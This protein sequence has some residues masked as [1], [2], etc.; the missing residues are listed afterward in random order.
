MSGYTTRGRYPGRD[1]G[2]TVPREARTGQAPPRSRHVIR[3]ADWDGSLSEALPASGPGD[4]IADDGRDGVRDE[5]TDP[6]R[7]AGRVI[8]SALAVLIVLGEWSGL[9]RGLLGGPYYAAVLDLALVATVGLAAL[10]AWRDDRLPRLHPIDV[11]V[12]GFAVLALIQVMNPNVPSLTVGLEGFRKTAFTMLGYA[13]IRLSG[14]RDPWPFYTIIA[15]GSIPALLWAIRQSW[16]P[17]PFDLQIITTSGVSSISFHAGV[18]M[19]AF[20]PTAGPFHLGILAGTVLIIAVVY[21]LR[22]GRW[23]PLALLAGTALGLSITRAN[24]GATAAAVVVMAIIQATGRDRLKLAAVGAPAIA[25]ALVF[26]SVAASAPTDPTTPAS[27]PPA[28]VDSGDGDGDGP[29]AELPSLE[30]DQNFQFRLQFWREQLEAIVERPLIGY[31]TSA[32]ADGFD[33]DYEGTG[34]RNFGPH[35]LYTKPALELG[36]I[37]FIVF[38]AILVG[39]FVAML[40][41]LSVNRRLATISI[42]LFVLVTVSGLTGPMLDAYPFNVIF[43]A[44]LGWVVVWQPARSPAVQPDPGAGA[45]LAKAP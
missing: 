17:Q 3:L 11:L 18:A 23:F 31:G 40:R 14:T 38:M 45:T 6:R 8:T 22:S 4:V 1:P 27:P 41:I 12:F 42:G 44:T 28:G 15:L 13:V 29:V 37:G 9:A 24:I 2:H 5:R 7:D 10:L 19:R 21:S 30:E 16:F 26:A 33:A 43:W 32:A 20:A 36:L 35:S 25:L 34:S 39:A